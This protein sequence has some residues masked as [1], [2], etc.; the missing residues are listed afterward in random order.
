MEAAET[1]GLEILM[2]LG[3][4]DNDALREERCPRAEEMHSWAQKDDGCCILNCAWD[5]MEIPA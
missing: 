4:A 1:P 5:K 3:R 2:C